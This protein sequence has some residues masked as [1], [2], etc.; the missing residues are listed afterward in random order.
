MTTRLSLALLLL[1]LTTPGL[2]E[3]DHPWRVFQAGKTGFASSGGRL[4]AA[5][6]Y[7]WVGAWSDGRLW[8]QE[9][10]G[11]GASG[12]FLDPSAKLVAP[13]RYRGLS[14][15]RPEL[16]LPAF[17]RGV[18]V[19]GLADGGF[20]YLDRSG[21]LLGRTSRAGAFMRQ[22][23]PLLLIVDQGRFGYIDRQG[24]SLPRRACRRGGG[25]P[26]GAD[27]C[28][29]RVGCPSRLRRRRVVCGGSARLE[30]PEG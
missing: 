21:R 16:P 9:E 4:L 2:A 25:R 6:I 19:V 13:A 24:T 10:V 1:G 30:L 18:A 29:R 17:E 26:M 23:D 22:D 12:T 15:I 28:R 14:A 8:V 7:A 20:G 27:R 3:G 5:P 11:P